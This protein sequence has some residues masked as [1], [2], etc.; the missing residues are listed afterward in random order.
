VFVVLSVCV[1][2]FECVCVCGFEC[3]SVCVCGFECVCVCVCVC[4]FEC[5]CLC[6]RSSCVYFLGYLWCWVRRAVWF[7]R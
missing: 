5:V 6:V 1:C 3:V 7:V 4:G 2:G